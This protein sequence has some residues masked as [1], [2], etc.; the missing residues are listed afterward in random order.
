M[1]EKAVV[2][3]IVAENMG[4]NVGDVVRVYTTRNFQEISH[5]YQQTELPMLAEKTRGNSRI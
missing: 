3:S 1:G 4:L 5:A 2:S